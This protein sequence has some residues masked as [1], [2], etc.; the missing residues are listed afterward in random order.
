VD[1][2]D[3]AINLAGALTT[4]NN[5]A[6]AVQIIDGTT[7]A[8]GNITAAS[9]TVVLGGAAAGDELSDNI[10][11]TAGTTLSSGPLVVN[12]A[13]GKNLILSNAGNSFAGAVT[14]LPSTGANRFNN[15]SILDVTTLDLQAGLNVG[16]D[17]NVT[18]LGITQAAGGITVVGNSSFNG[19][20]AAI[21]LNDAANN[22][23]G[24]VSLQNTGA[25]NIQ[26]TDNSALSLHNVSMGVANAGSLTLISAGNITQ[27][28][29]TTITTGTGNVTLTAPNG[30]DVTVANAGNA[31][32]G[33]LVLQASGGIGSLLANVS[34][35]DTT[36]LVMPAGLRVSNNLSLN[37]AGITQ[38]D[39]ITPAIN[40]GAFVVPGTLTVTSSADVLLNGLLG[41]VGINQITNLD[42]VSMTGAGSDFVLFDQGGGLNL[43]NLTNLPVS[44]S[45]S[46]GVKIVTD[47]GMTVNGTVNVA[48]GALFTTIPLPDDNTPTGYSVVLVANHNSV[49]GTVGGPDNFNVQS[50]SFGATGGPGVIYVDTQSAST[51]GNFVPLNFSPNTVFVGTNNNNLNF[52]NAGSTQWVLA[53]A[54]PLEVNDQ[55]GQL[56]IDDLF[57]KLME[58]ADPARGAKQVTVDKGR[59]KQLNAL[60]AAFKQ[61]RSKGVIDPFSF[62]PLQFLG[63]D[64][65]DLM[66]AGYGTPAY[67]PSKVGNETPKSILDGLPLTN[68]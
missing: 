41:V 32:N 8:L 38:T 62:G 24:S 11:Q 63:Y 29:A 13:N 40:S 65:Q 44:I 31:F 47:G 12:G 43:T 36:L 60:M 67:D 49:A 2:N 66:D 20:A 16:G 48:T 10:S 1:G 14:I 45:S 37:V 50:G 9:G 59:R 39:L 30:A 15:V 33:P 7:A 35:L 52:V 5:T 58:M 28:A 25:N 46:G 21:V 54:G 19:G 26:L 3:G 27:V 55:A 56:N 6:T 18:A 51:L 61:S 4:T 53:I 64:F 34:I 57:K 42:A 23:A 22:F 17:L 68:Q